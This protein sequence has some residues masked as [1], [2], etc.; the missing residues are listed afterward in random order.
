M[1]QVN[2]PLSKKLI[3]NIA[4]QKLLISL[5]RRK[6]LSKE[7]LRESLILKLWRRNSPL[8][9]GIKLILQETTVV[10]SSISNLPGK[11]NLKV[12]LEGKRM[13]PWTT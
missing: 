1:D 5:R 3:N 4:F 9:S 7:G 8:P 13:P 11:I 12:E 10:I 6:M 2:L